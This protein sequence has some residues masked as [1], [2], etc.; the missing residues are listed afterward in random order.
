[1]FSRLLFR[2]NL[3]CDACN[4]E[5]TGFAIQVKSESGSDSK[6]P[7]WPIQSAPRTNYTENVGSALASDVVTDDRPDDLESASDEAGSGEAVKE[8]VH[9]VAI[10]AAGSETGVR[11]RSGAVARKTARKSKATLKSKKPAAI[12]E[13]PTKGRKARPK[14]TKPTNAKPRGVNA[15]AASPS[16]NGESQK[17]TV[18]SEAKKRLKSSAPKLTQKKAAKSGK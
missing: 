18:K 14:S 10:D 17:T 11:E 4:W 1:M 5:F 2:Y 6:K 15:S 7:E 8:E 9:A 3:L 13:S 16:P 12:K